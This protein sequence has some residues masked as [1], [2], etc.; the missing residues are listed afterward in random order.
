MKKIII[1]LLTVLLIFTAAGCTKEEEK[2]PIAGS[3]L[4]LTTAQPELDEN[5]AEATFPPDTEFLNPSAFNDFALD[6]LSAYSKK[7]G[8]VVLSPTSLAASLTVL[9]IGANGQTADQ[10]NDLLG[11]HDIAP[12]DLLF[13]IA[14]LPEYLYYEELVMGMANGIFLGSGPS[15]NET[16][17]ASLE[18]FLDTQLSFIDLTDILAIDNINDWVKD[19]TGGRIVSVVDSLPSDMIMLLIN[20]IAFD[21]QWELGF[22]ESDTITMPFILE[23]EKGVAVPML[24]DEREIK[25]YEGDDATA[26]YLP[27][28]GSDQELWILLPP[29]DMLIEDFMQTL[30]MESLILWKN[31]AESQVRTI[32][33]PKLDFHN[34][35]DMTEILPDMGVID[36][37]D[38]K[39]CDL[40]AMGSR[41]HLQT[42]THSVLFRIKEHG[43]I[44]AD[45]D[46]VIISIRSLTPEN[47]FAIDRPYIMMVVDVDTTGILFASIMRNPLES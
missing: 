6:I 42:F 23:N 11:T 12:Q 16:Y 4:K 27:F 37:F 35:L 26:T 47:L 8:N 2:I 17:A 22:S 15:V 41:L 31:S 25:L 38:N 44:P 18:S 13:K 14:K 20:A 46:D 10:I 33:L 3:E 1:L 30:T 5:I 29:E 19:V 28:E 43:R 40:T 9:R 45:D 39:L 24:S 7:E 36:I 21:S 34:T 32:R